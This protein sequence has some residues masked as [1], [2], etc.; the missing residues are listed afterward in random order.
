MSEIF[1]LRDKFTL[2]SEN[3]IEQSLYIIQKKVVFDSGEK[4]MIEILV[5]A[6]LIAKNT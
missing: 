5:L 4:D 2:E 6:K 3:W 1:L